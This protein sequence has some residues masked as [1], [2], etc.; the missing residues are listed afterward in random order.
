MFN[1]LKAIAKL[2]G[3]EKE[4]GQE[5]VEVEKNGVK[6]VVNGRFEVEDI[7]LNPEIS[8]KDQSEILKTCFNEALREIQ[9]KALEKMLK[10]NIK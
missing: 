7:S 10:L 3:I 9:T 2:K 8:L 5:R 1:Q 6:V 4:L